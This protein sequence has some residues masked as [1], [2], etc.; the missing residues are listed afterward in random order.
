M[1]KAGRYQIWVNGCPTNNTNN[2]LTKVIDLA[3]RL[4][5]INKRQY[6]VR[7]PGGVVVWTSEGK[8]GQ[9]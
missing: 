3:H 6:Q 2:D 5:L 7:G 8:G 4:H 1:A 9:S